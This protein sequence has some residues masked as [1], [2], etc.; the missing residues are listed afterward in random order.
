M[1][2]DFRQVFHLPEPISLGFFTSPEHFERKLRKHFLNVNEPWSRLLGVK[3]LHQVGQKLAADDVS[4][5]GE[6][7]RQVVSV[8]DEGVRFSADCPLFLAVR[9]TLTVRG[10]LPRKLRCLFLLAK[11]GFR[12]VAH[13]G[14]IQTAYFQTKSRNDSYFTLFRE[15]WG[16]LRASGLLRR[17]ELT[18]RTYE[19][20]DVK[21]HNEDTWSKCPNPH[22]ERRSAKRSQRLPPAVQA[23]LTEIDG[24]AND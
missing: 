20:L 23:W 17:I 13:S 5:L 8:L 9:Q 18:D 15:S 14:F 12:I 19:R 7:Y 1:L 4:M 21:W 10:S 11:P 2:A 24:V 3:F 6:A 16:S 22:P